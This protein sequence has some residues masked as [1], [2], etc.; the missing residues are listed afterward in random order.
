[1]KS[2]GGAHGIVPYDGNTVH[3]PYRTQLW[4]SVPYRTVRHKFRICRFPFFLKVKYYP[5]AYKDAITLLH[6]TRPVIRPL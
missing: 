6:L 3:V 1:M 4:Y 2:I 5:P